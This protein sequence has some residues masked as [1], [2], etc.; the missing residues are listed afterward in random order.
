MNPLF[1]LLVLPETHRYSPTH[2]RFP[3]L[4]KVKATRSNSRSRSFS[5]RR[6]LLLVY[7]ASK[8]HFQL[9]LLLGCQSG[10]AFSPLCLSFFSP[11]PRSLARP[12]FSPRPP[13]PAIP[14][15]P[16]SIFLHLFYIC[17]SQRALTWP[18]GNSTAFDSV[19]DNSCLRS[20]IDSSIR[21]S[22]LS[23][24]SRFKCDGRTKFSL[25]IRTVSKIRW[26]LAV[27][28]IDEAQL[29]ISIISAYIFIAICIKS[30]YEYPP[31]ILRQSYH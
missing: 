10:R 2:R 9:Q 27:L 15:V 13:F 12:S 7:S 20:L 17:F 6:G 31:E 5:L 23:S 11:L 22:P 8:L 19:I 1:P 28:A 16:S 21:D 24:P 25:K 4:P 14:G 30:R 18:Y 26:H 3:A 29:N